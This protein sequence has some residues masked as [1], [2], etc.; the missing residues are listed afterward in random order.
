MSPGRAMAGSLPLV[1][2]LAAASGADP[3]AVVS[4][5]DD[6]RSMADWYALGGW[7][8][9]LVAGCSVLAGAVLLERLVALRRSAVAPPGLAARLEEAWD[10]CR[11]E[12]A[13]RLCEAAPSSLARLVSAGLAAAQRGAE[14]PLEHVFM[15]G[16]AEAQRLRRNLPLLA[17]LANVATMIG[18]LGTVLGM[19]QAFD[20]IAAV[21][22]GDARVVARGIFQAL[23]TTAAGLSV[24]IGA[25]AAHAYL[26]RRVD[27]QLLALEDVVSRLFEDGSPAVDREVARPATDLAAAVR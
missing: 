25:L 3:T 8:M 19:I 12:A 18:L 22:T 17:T 13:Q 10:R 1:V 15:A 5:A 16:E 9:H 11:P 21:G 24:G 26:R 7:I 20:Q 6:G 23:I 14:H 27:A 2:A 4:A